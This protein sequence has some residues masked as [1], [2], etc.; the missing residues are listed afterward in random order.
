MTRPILNAPVGFSKPVID[1]VERLLEILSALHDDPMLTDAFVLHGGTALNLFHDDAPRLSVDIDLLFVAEPELAAMRRARPDVD[2]RFRRVVEGLGYLVQGTNDEHS[3]QTYRVKYPGDYVK[4]DVS[5]L[6]RVPL[7][8]PELRVCTLSEPHVPFPTLRFPELVA[9]KVKALLE[10]TAARD[11]YD[12]WRIAVRHPFHFVDPLARACAIYA[13]SASDPFPYTKRPADALARFENPAADLAEPLYAM[14][15]PG[16]TPEFSEMV[17]VVRSWLA[18][19]GNT[20]RAEA[21]YMRLLEDRAE[22]RPE[23]LFGEDSETASRAL[24]DPV[25]AWKVQNLAK[26]GQGG[27]R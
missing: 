27:G 9:G 1:K 15:R 12:L 16:D 14:L 23:L 7:L 20:T 6:A 8:Q 18:P 13:M 2:A 19:L 25:M 26:R 11:L 24:Q 22:F 10:R 5:Y 3:G 21:E 4:V 17:S